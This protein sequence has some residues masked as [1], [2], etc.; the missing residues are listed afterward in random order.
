MAFLTMS[1]AELVHA[2]NV[3][4]DKSALIT[5]FKGNPVLLA[6]VCSAVVLSVALCYIPAAAE[7]FG[8]TALGVREWAAVSL[9]SLAMLPLGD[10][11]KICLKAASAQSRR[12]RKKV[13]AQAK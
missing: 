8:L 11:Y 7:A 2:L 6:T 10:L 13:G 12:C 9:L 3:R 4:S 5:R 1:F